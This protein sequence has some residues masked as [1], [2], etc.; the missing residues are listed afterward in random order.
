M[1]LAVT[2]MVGLLIQVGTT[3]NHL[4]VEL[5]GY[6]VKEL[7]SDR[8]LVDFSA[9]IAAHKLQVVGPTVVPINMNLCAYASRPDGGR[10]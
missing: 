2:C 8:S 5:K 4:N 10:E 3:V 6:E 9:D 7:S 1:S